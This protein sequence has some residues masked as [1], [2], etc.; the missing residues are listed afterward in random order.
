[1][2]IK[3]ANIKNLDVKVNNIILFYGKN[4]GLKNELIDKLTKNEKISSYEEKEILSDKDVFL[5]NIF[6]R[7]FFEEKKNIIIKR[8]TDKILNLIELIHSKNLEDLF[9]VIAENLEKKSKLRTFFEKDKKLICIPTYPD[10]ER[11]LLKFILEYLRKKNISISQSNINQILNVSSGD[12]HN[13]LN[14]LKKIENYLRGGGK[15]TSENLSKLINL[16]ENFD[17][18]ELIENCLAKNKSKTIKIL[19]EN[20]FNNDD[21]MIITRSLLYKL[22]SLLQLSL[23]Y[24]K[25]RNIDLTI[26]NSKPPIFWKNKTITKQQLLKWK[27]KDIKKLIYNLND[28][29]IVI[30]KN[31]NNSL[32]LISD[33]LLKNAS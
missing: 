24:E 16:S 14:E 19:N 7:S 26:S 6:N 3:S 22:K 23:D 18:S 9:I 20:N 29:E 10:D 28:I 32:N 17:V 15:L 13:L 2:I 30:K 31:F 4:E 11:T 12:R 25:N 21:C 33:F 5:E 1:M 8:S 27:S